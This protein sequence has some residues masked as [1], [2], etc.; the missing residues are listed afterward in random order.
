MPQLARI[1]VSQGRL[2]TMASS[3]EEGFQQ[4]HELVL[5]QQETDPVQKLPA[6]DEPPEVSTE[7]TAAATEAD[8]G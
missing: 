3:L 7:T 1:I 5:R 4:L 2:V 8:S 6:P